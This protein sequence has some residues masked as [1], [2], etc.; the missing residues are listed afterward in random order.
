MWVS[1]F[2]VCD[3][4]SFAFSDYSIVNSLSAGKVYKL[5]DSDKP[6]ISPPSNFEHTVHVGF[7]AHTGEFTVSSLKTVPLTYSF[8]FS[9]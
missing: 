6:V 2:D 1:S 4:L 8:L 3:C 9:R 7:D 5:K